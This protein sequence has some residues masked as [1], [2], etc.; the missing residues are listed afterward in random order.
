MIV[1][2]LK[3][4]LTHRQEQALE[5]WLWNLT[6]VYNWGIRKI[7]LNAR[8]K[9]YFS[10]KTFQN[11]LADH[12]KKLGVP[13]HTIQGTLLQAHNAWQ[14]CFR[15][16]AKA[17]RLKGRRNKLNSIPFPDPIKHPDDKRLASPEL[18]RSGFINR[19]C[20]MQKSNVAE[21]SKERQD[22]IYVSGWTPH[23]SSR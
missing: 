8:D 17:P 23:T 6:G 15:K 5:Q 7:E 20:P 21:S 14:R 12:G 11:L 3:L 9:I 18:A 13:S 16:Q 2:T 1:R 10:E 22:G 19:N 4:K